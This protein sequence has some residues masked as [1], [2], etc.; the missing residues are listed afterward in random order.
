M[1]SQSTER[2][3]FRKSLD[4]EDFVKESRPIVQD[5]KCPLCEGIYMNPV[6]DNCGHVFCRTCIVQYIERERKCPFSQ[7]KLEENHVTKLVLVKDILEKQFVLCKNRI[8]YCNWVGKLCE[9]ERHLNEDCTRQEVVCPHIGCTSTVF[10]EDLK[11]HE[12]LCEYRIVDCQDCEIQIA[13]VEIKPHQDVCPKFKVPCPQE[14]GALVERKE[15][16]GHILEACLNT[17][18]DCPYKDIGCSTKITKKELESYLTGS[19]NRHNLMMVSFLKRF[20][21]DIQKKFTSIESNLTLIPEEI[22]KKIDQSL[23][24]VG[25][26]KE[27]R[28]FK[29][30]NFRENT[31][32]K[33]N[34]SSNSSPKVDIKLTNKKRKRMEEDN[35]MNINKTSSS[36]SSDSG[37]E[38][39]AMDDGDQK[40][41]HNSIQNNTLTSTSPVP[42]KKSSPSSSIFDSVNISKGL[43]LS[44]SKVAC[45][46]S[47][48]AEHRYVFANLNLNEEKECEWKCVL[49]VSSHWAAIGVCIKEQVIS[50]KFK[51]VTNNISFYNATFAISTNGYSWNCN[52]ATEF[53]TYLMNFPTITKGD[54]ISFKYNSDLKEVYYQIP[55]KFTGKL[56]N[57]CALKQPGTLVPCII[58]LNPGDEV[59]FE[60]IQ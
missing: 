50:N 34:T 30:I 25:S 11:T 43:Q 46:N 15:I 41:Q 49:N 26:L 37:R 21:V 32:K 60:A 47:S 40:D 53:N 6:V 28:E 19:T 12:G 33:F 22:N 7:W 3:S 44:H 51:F 35:P 36:A 18:V 16:S 38:V 13:F 45:V 14:C 27:I 20:T 2:E 9:L 10:R 54:V 56:T 4:L 31:L 55:N 42:E 23:G 17:V 5:Y 8:F 29:E 1:T 39:I 58:L 52:T 48:K 57:V 24:L 59:V